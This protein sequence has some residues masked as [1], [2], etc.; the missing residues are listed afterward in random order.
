[1]ETSKSWHWRQRKFWQSMRDILK[2]YETQIRTF[3]KIERG[4]IGKH[5]LS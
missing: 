5:L 3:R 4:K 1:M 2:V